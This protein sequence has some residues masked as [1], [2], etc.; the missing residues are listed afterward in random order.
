MFVVAFEGVMHYKDEAHYSFIYKS[1][2]FTYQFAD[3]LS[4]NTDNIY[5][6][7]QPNYNT[8]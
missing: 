2:K 4:K 7:I 1:H 3:E 6:T 5:T 8:S